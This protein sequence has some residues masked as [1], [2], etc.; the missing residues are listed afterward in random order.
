MV[1][2]DGLRVATRCENGALALDYCGL[3]LGK[4]MIGDH[5]SPLRGSILILMSGPANS[6]STSFRAYVGRDLGMVAFYEFLNY[7]S[8]GVRRVRASQVILPWDLWED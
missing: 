6:I 8:R 7:S 3:G 2:D 1:L 5:R 4:G